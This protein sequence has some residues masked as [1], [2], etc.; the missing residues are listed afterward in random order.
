[1]PELPGTQATRWLSCALLDPE[2]FGTTPEQ[3]RQALEA[4]NIEARPV[5]KPM[6][7]QTVYSDHRV[8]GGS[9]SEQLFQ[10][11]ICLPSGTSMS[12]DDLRR[13]CGIVRSCHQMNRSVSQAA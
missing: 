13:I 6:H 7:L 8:R 12:E 4:E 11:G 1:M 10:Q 2:K 9:V 5:W 3:V